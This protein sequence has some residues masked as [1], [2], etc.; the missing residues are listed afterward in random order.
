MD[1]ESENTQDEE[2]VRQL[3]EHQLPLRLFIRSIMSGRDEAWDALQQ[4]NAVLWRKKHQF[5][6]GTNFRA[7]AFKIARYEALMLLRKERNRAWLLFDDNMI[8]QIEEEMPT[9]SY[10]L[11]RRQQALENCMQNLKDHD[12]ELIRRRYFHNDH[13]ETYALEL[14]RT[15]G[16]LKTRLFRIRAALRRCILKQLAITE[17]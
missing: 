17:S 1:Q 3:T 13:L 2:F 15:A 9:E 10:D 16:T 8:D 14:G 6:P 11:E 12:K 4:T 7:W 5:E